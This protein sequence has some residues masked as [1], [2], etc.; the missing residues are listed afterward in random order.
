VAVCEEPG[1]LIVV[2]EGVNLG[3][4]VNALNAI[5]VTPRDLVAILQSLK[6]A[7]ALMADL[8]MI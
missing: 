5:G 1:H 2:P 3:D 4:V 8:E 6:A 7:G